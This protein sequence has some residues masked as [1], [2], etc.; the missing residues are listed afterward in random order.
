MEREAGLRCLWNRNP[1][2]S[3]DGQ[4]CLLALSQSKMRTEDHNKNKLYL[5][6]GKTLILLFTSPR[7]SES[8][9]RATAWLGKDKGEK[10]HETRECLFFFF[11]S[12]CCHAWSLGSTLK[13][14]V[15]V[16]PGQ[17]QGT[18][19]VPVPVCRVPSGLSPPLAAP[20]AVQGPEGGEGG[21][22][23]PEQE[24]AP[25]DGLSFLQVGVARQ[26]HIDF[27]GRERRE[28]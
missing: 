12:L 7:R 10:A 13:H 18:W 2:V 8:R 22:C 9:V 20:S 27:S 11:Q 1:S 6:K 21:R 3:G 28:R 16:E 17:S 4:I 5:P 24:L 26:D 25:S 15:G 14:E 19:G 23:S